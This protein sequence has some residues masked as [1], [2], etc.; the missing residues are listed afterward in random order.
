MKRRLL[1]TPSQVSILVTT[2]IGKGPDLDVCSQRVPTTDKPAP[3]LL[4][5][6]ALFLSGYVIQQRTVRQLR[7]S[8][9]QPPRP[10][11]KIYLPDRFQTSTTELE[12]GTVIVLDSEAERES[13]EQREAMALKVTPT[14]RE[15]ASPVE[16]VIAE[17]PEQEAD[18]TQVP[19]DKGSLEV[20]SH[21]LE[22]TE[23]TSDD[24]EL[25]ERERNLQQQKERNQK[26]PDPDADDQRPI[27]RAERRRLIKEELF[28]LSHDDQPVYYQRRLW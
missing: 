22:S 4:F 23:S 2:V 5:T 28:K 17:A 11:P 8:I 19:A 9:R 24:E 7:M 6:T 20:E 3:V 12:D 25:D 14:V 15:E 16:H 10:S 27:T 18:K 21:E 26:H 13:R 1:L